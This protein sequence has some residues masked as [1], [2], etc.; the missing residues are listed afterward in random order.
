MSNNFYFICGAGKCGTT[1]VKC[2]LDGDKHINVYPVELTNLI[3]E[4]I[5]LKKN[6]SKK[7]CYNF[8][9]K[10]LKV[11][12]DKINILTQ[13]VYV[14][15]NETLEKILNVI[16]EQLFSN[17]KPT[18]F[19][20]TDPSS[21][22]YLENFK[23]SKVIHLIRHPESSLNSQFFE[24]YIKFKNITS[25]KRWVINSHLKRMEE[26]FLSLNKISK[27]KKFLKRLL[28]IKLEDLQENKSININKICKFLNLKYSK[29]FYKLTLSGKN[30][31]SASNLKKTNKIKILKHNKNYLTKFEKSLANN[32][33]YS[34]LYYK[35]DRKTNIK[36]TYLEYILRNLKYMY[37]INLFRFLIYT[38][39]GFINEKYNLKKN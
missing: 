34:D 36:F 8:C 37:Q 10:F 18:L 20:V 6:K 33:K 23:K 19:D 27:N 3:K 11:K 38:Y 30:F 12:S 15:L 14:N 5:K 32:I 7:S 1:L 16:N 26:S 31:Y 17:D 39:F 2:M 9:S 25:L 22:K 21:F 4:L 24:R 35:L 13:E 29:N 28:L